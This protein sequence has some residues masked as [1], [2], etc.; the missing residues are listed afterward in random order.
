MPSY[1][2]SSRVHMHTFYALTVS[3]SVAIHK[4]Y[5]RQRVIYSSL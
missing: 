5:I 1:I 3:D 4:L 2:K